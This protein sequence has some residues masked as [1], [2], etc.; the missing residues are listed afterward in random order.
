MHS[1]I[2]EYKKTKTTNNLGHGSIN[3]V[4][5]NICIQDFE[6]WSGE[7][8]VRTKAN[9]AGLCSGSSSKLNKDDASMSRSWR[10]SNPLR[11]AE[12]RT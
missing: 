1:I 11:P 6:L 12:W 8:V 5:A 3:K 4:A 9:V 10:R 2:Y 7:S